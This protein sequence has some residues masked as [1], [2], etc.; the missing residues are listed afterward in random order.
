MKLARLDRNGQIFWALGCDDNTSVREIKGNFH[1]WAPRLTRGGGADALSLSKVKVSIDDVTFLPPVEPVNRIVVAGANYSKHLEEFGVDPVSKPVAFLKAYGALI[2]AYDDIRY[3]PLTQKLDHEV[4]L[5]AV[6]GSN[7]VDVEDPYACI[8]GYTVGNDV[9][10]RDLQRD[11]SPK[12]GMDLFAAKSQ[13]QTTGLGPW[14]V[15]KD[16]F[17]KGSPALKLTLKV[18]GE[19]RQ[20]ANSG[21]MTFPVGELVKYVQNISRFRAGDIL[22]TGSPPGVGD[23]TGTYL[24]RGDLVEAEVENIGVLRNRIAG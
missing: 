10:A 16:E 5:V 17:A 8:L 2:G 18:N 11:G 20:N 21:D 19:L 12:I 9:S 14:I 24:N 6:I 23:A 1:E 13:D 7:D 3:P 22:F 4:E 15:T